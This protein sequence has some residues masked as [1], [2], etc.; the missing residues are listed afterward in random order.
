MQGQLKDILP[1]E[2]LLLH[3]LQLFGIT[4]AGQGL[5]LIVYFAKLVEQGNGIF[6]VV[7]TTTVGESPAEMA[8]EF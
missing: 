7:F 5:K 8:V 3:V 6:L 4:H 1:R 2:F